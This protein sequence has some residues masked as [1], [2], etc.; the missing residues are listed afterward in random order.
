[1]LVQNSGR[2]RRILQTT[3]QTS[4]LL[5]VLA[6]PAAAF[7]LKP[8]GTYATGIFDDGASE[9]SAYDPVTQR[10]FVTNG[11]TGQIDILNI[12]DPTKPLL[13]S[14]IALS[15]YGSGTNSVAFKNGI[16]A[17]A[18]ENVVTQDPGSVVFFDANGN[19]LNSVT[20]G[21]LPDMLTFA[22]DGTK[23][24]VANEGEPNDDYTID[25]EGS[26]S[27][28]DISG[29][30]S[31]AT[32]KTADFRQFN[33]TPLDPS[34]RIFGPN[35]TVAQDLEPEYITVF[36]DSTK[37][38]VALQEN[39]A[40]GIL[41]L[42]TGEFEQLIGLGFKDHSLPENAL[43][44]S[45][46][47]NA[48]NI[49]PYPNLFGIYQPDAI[50]SYTVGGKTY[51]VT[52]NEGDTRDYDGFSE[53]ARV[54]TLPLDPSTFPNAAELQLNSALGRLTVTNTLG[55]ADGDGLFEELYAFGGRSFSIRDED[56]NL[57]YD[58]GD[59][60]ERITADR[61]PSFFNANHADNEFDSR[62]D[63]KGPEPEGVTIGQ[64]A[65]RTFA[66]VTLERI[67]G[68]MVYD[69]SDPFAPFFVNYT[70]NRDFSVLFDE[71]EEGSAPTPTQLAAAGDLG[72]E[73]SLLIPASD[74]PTARPLLVL[75]NEVSGTTTIYS[76]EVPEPASVLG[77]VAFFP[78]GWLLKRKHK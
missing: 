38:W 60:F 66:F 15:P 8:I 19:F 16:L 13:F 37:A 25:P 3:V 2:M 17:A 65:G 64:L 20:A 57:I 73:S 35:A 36:E 14:S 43:D 67:G 70:N 76:V 22:P 21:A 58:S 41:N 33:N 42:V 5:S 61:F 30:V 32:V 78:L 68:I 18:V 74:S 53:E 6:S 54:R 12:S 71:N 45:D 11:S 24:L 59:D 69:I 7:S 47:D 75:S 55:D 77:F 9:I 28:V 72:P 49:T 39:N 34:I 63:A 46:R 48:I 51:I 23:V 56:G 62:S 10:L 27:I 1:M 31:N 52:A 40:L 29:G 44:A 26:V 50:A 4:L